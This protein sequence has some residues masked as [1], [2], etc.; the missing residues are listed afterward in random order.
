M[1]QGKTLGIIYWKDYQSYNI[2]S[3]KKLGGTQIVS[4]MICGI[5]CIVG[6]TMVGNQKCEHLQ[7]CGDSEYYSAANLSISS[8]NESESK[9]QNN[10][11]VNPFLELD[12]TCLILSGLVS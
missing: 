8:Q 4:A 7:M 6:A 12:I 1:G 5:L 10:Y 11:S 2:G 3:L 9:E